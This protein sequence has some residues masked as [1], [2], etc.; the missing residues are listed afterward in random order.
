MAAAG[1]LIRERVWLA[2][3][4]FV[5]RTAEGWRHLTATDEE[6]ATPIPAGCGGDGSDPAYPR[7]PE[8]DCGGRIMSAEATRQPGSREC[9]TCGA[10]WTDTRFAP[11]WREGCLAGDHRSKPT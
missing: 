1:A 7:C 5:V 6:V 9:E 8:A 11:D 3:D 4:R 10:R 2:G